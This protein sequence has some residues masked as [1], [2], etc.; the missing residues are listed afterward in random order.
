MRAGGCPRPESRNL[1][2]Y[3]AT[4]YGRRDRGRSLPHCPNLPE[5]GP[6]WETKTTSLFYGTKGKNN[7][8]LS[9]S[10]VKFSKND[11]VIYE[12]P[13]D[14]APDDVIRAVRSFRQGIGKFDFDAFDGI[15]ESL[16]DGMDKFRKDM[17][18][19]RDDMDD[20]GK[21]MDKL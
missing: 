15:S 14:D 6:V 2:H 5:P 17:D 1:P 21:E 8:E 19:F 4:A 9:G 11:E 7:I 13:L 18:K 3:P 16:N 20:F 10:H 12:G